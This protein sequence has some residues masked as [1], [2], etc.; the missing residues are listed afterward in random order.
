MEKYMSRSMGHL[1]CHYKKNQY[2]VKDGWIIYKV[3][4]ANLEWVCVHFC[5]KEFRRVKLGVRLV[6]SQFDGGYFSLN[7]P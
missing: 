2:L 5:G 1:S 6:R 4:S 7:D 3:Q